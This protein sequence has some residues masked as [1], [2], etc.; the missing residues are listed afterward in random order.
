MAAAKEQ[1]ANIRKYEEIGTH[2]AGNHNAIGVAL[3]FHR[4]IGVERKSA[5]LKWLRDRWAVRI[6]KENPRIRV[7]TPLDGDRALVTKA[8]CALPVVAVFDD[9]EPGIQAQKVLREIGKK[10]GH[11]GDAGV[12]S[13]YATKTITTGEGGMLV[14]INKLY[15]ST[16]L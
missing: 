14:S 8:S 13:F 10:T 3:A 7:L 11:W 4:G 16:C 2:P 5:R 6:T 1:D 9:D 15:I 12:Y